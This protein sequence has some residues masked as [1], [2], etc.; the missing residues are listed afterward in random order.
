LVLEGRKKMKGALSKVLIVVGIIFIVAAILWWAI[1]VPALVKF[2][3]NVDSAPVYEGDVDIYQNPLTGELLAKPITAKLTIERAYKSVDD[4]YD[5]GKAV[6]Q[7]TIT[8]TIPNLTTIV[9]SSQY[10][11]DR[12]TIENINDSR[13][14]AYT[15]GN[16]VDRSGTFYINF[17]FDLNKDQAY[18]VFENK[19]NTYYE[20]TKNTESDEED[21]DGLK[22]YNFVGE[23][24]A[25][26]LAPYY[27][28]YSKY[29]TTMSFDE[30]KQSLS[31][32]GIDIDAFL[33]LLTP[34]LEPADAAT[35]AQL[36]TQ[37]INLNYQYSNA[38]NV[39]IE[40]K[41]GSI[42]RLSN[43]VEDITVSPD[44]SKLV[45]TLKPLL[46]K[47]KDRSAELTA[48]TEKILAALPSL[49]QAPPQ[50]VY[51]ARYSQTE[52]SVKEA[53]Q[54]AKDSIGK[55]NWV[56]VYI[57]WILLILGAAVLV[58]GLLMGGSPAALEEEAEEATE[59]PEE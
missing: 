51:E 1:A 21:V 46:A 16:Q 27:V 36:A 33:T 9:E 59:I 25:T 34:V 4:Q 41:T 11:L 18:K 6:V 57:P 20:I 54:D 10:V 3:E 12:K 42:V 55:I 8:Q 15:E 47:Y 43:V 19:V 49:L 30:L 56:K 23:I 45:D 32:A 17:P 44:I 7:E 22:V 40:P 35:L 24:K 31:P 53:V 29:P 37:P 38:G 50:K 58:G 2:P 28:T 13:S 52:E 48:A 39:S 14:W 26:D 5:S